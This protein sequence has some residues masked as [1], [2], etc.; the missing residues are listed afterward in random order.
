MRILIATER[1]AREDFIPCSCIFSVGHPSHCFSHSSPSSFLYGPGNSPLSTSMPGL[2]YGSSLLPCLT[3]CPIPMFPKASSLLVLCG[4]NVGSIT[5]TPPLTTLLS[6]WHLTSM[7]NPEIWFVAALVLDPSVLLLVPFLG[8]RGPDPATMP[9]P[10]SSPQ[11]LWELLELK[12]TVPT[13]D[14]PWHIAPC[15]TQ[16]SLT[17]W[18]M[19]ELQLV[20]PSALQISSSLLPL[21]TSASKVSMAPTS[22]PGLL[23][24]G[25]LS[26]TMRES[27]M[28]SRFVILILWLP[29][30]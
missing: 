5:P 10:L 2:C 25:G 8:A 18:L 17:S 23:L 9:H 14:P 19:G 21:P 7:S 24:F 28:C 16:I 4:S 15:L 3:P 27:G 29:V 26:Q 1:V 20:S 22:L 6:S 13:L 12:L 30:P 11:S